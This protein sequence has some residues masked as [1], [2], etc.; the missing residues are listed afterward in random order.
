MPRSFRRRLQT[1]R[2]VLRQLLPAWLCFLVAALLDHPLALIVLLAANALTLAGICR[3]FGFGRR[4]SFGR[5]AARRGATYFVSLSLYTAFVATIVGW[6]AWSL[7][8]GGSLAGALLLSLAI[9]AAVFALWRVWPVFSLPFLWDDAYPPNGERGSWLLVALRRSLAFARHLT[10]EHDIFFAFGLP[11]GLA[12]LTL[13]AGML[14]LVVGGLLVEPSIRVAAVLA[15]GFAVAPMA[16]LVIVN[17]ALRAL[18][19]N[20]RH[21]RKPRRRRAAEVDQAEPALAANVGQAELDATLLCAARSAQ[22][23]L[24][25]AALERGADPDALPP[26][27]QRDQ[28]SALM[29]A[30]TLPDARLL[31]ALISAGADV[32]RGHAGITPLIIATRD[33]YQG[34]HDAVA[35]LLANGADP[36][37]TDAHGNAPIHHAALCADA[38]IAAM[39]LD[40]GADV[41]AVNQTGMTALGLAC[42]GANWPVAGFLLERGAHADVAQ[43]Q[44]ALLFAAAAPDD[45]VGGTRLLLKRRAAVDACDALGRTALMS[46][47][48]AGNPRNLALL[49]AAGAA[50][51]RA[52]R[53][54]TTALMEAARAGCAEAVR[55]LGKHQGDPQRLDADGRDALMIACR[56]RHASEDCVRALLALGADPARMGEDG[57]RAVDHAAAAGRW[58]L[59][60]LLDPAHHLPSSFGKPDFGTASADH[61]L[62]ALRHQRWDLAAGFDDAIADWPP[63]TLAELYEDLAAEQ[64]AEARCWLLN[65]GVDADVRLGDGRS[66]FTTLLAGLPDTTPALRDL[67]ERG[68]PVGGAGVVAAALAAA[69]GGPAGA[70]TRALAQELV[71]R[72]ADC[73]GTHPEDR[74][75]ALHLAV[76]AADARLTAHLLAHGADPDARDAQGHT[77]LHLALGLP[78]G[79]AIPVLQQLLLAGANLDAPTANGETALGLALVRDQPDL[80]WWLDWSPWPLPRRRLRAGDLVAAAAAGDRAAVAR[81]LELDLPLDSVDG[82]GATALIR[83]AGA[84]HT[85]LVVEL[86]EAGA[87]PAITAH[88]GMHALAAAV[89]A[90]RD[91][92]VHTLLSHGVAADL[93][94]SGGATSLALA[95]A[96]GQV[97]LADTLLQAGADA[98]AADTSGNTPLHAAAQFAFERGDPD[99]ATALFELLLRHGARP[100]SRN[101]AGQDVVL[102]L[103]GAGA[104]PGAPCDADVLRRLLEHLLRNGA[105]LDIQDQRGVSALHACAMHGLL[106]CA[107][108]LK[109]YGASLD[110]VDSLGRRAADVAALLGYTD[111]A[112]ELDCLA[113]TLPGVRQTLR[114]PARLQD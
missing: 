109:S 19:A 53:R 71:A 34:R 49:L 113:D 40:A 80:A 44:P 4:G 6:P 84:G 35:T 36:R 7:L 42:R 16:H 41:D 101:H 22:I 106:G 104:K 63:S 33:S 111:V 68:A 66:L 60:A 69:S 94:L 65:R 39:L 93:P 45:D 77:P 32:N 97:A 88:V 54:G 76:L 105:T 55:A 103:L 107:R 64:H 72:G 28:R 5:N 87:D 70:A 23:N 46:A 90:R 96:L 62:E 43:A 82:H 85:A 15:Y 99:V 29:L 8:R 86:L 17:R 3:A 24:A 61:L 50:V 112:N 9:T 89:S 73:C 92:V 114:Q 18:L 75:T 108:L 37:A 57:Q 27:G 25:L 26:D 78:T 30:T 51:D 12:L 102:I 58:P 14:A 95:A 67:V 74:R 83:A 47:A 56:S 81:L 1:L 100:G 2:A 48:L 110:L 11:S 98:N 91:T 10:A 59:V 13:A 20:A 52:D 38:G 21:A 31:R 79:Q